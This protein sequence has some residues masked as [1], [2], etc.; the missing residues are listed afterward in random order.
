VS[1]IRVFACFDIEHDKDLG[2]R[3]SADSRRGGSSFQLS[4]RSEGGDV[5]DRW[6]AQTRARIRD[7]DHVIVI[8]GEHTAA[9]T[10]VNEELRIAQEEQKPYF[11]LWGRRERMCTMPPLAKRTESM[12]SWTHEV[13][14]Q[15]LSAALQNTQ[16][17]V[18][19]VRKPS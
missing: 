1:D 18:M 17:R 10:K 11:L 12:Y 15:Q 9:C 7:A 6:C 8:C 14:L 19:P 2:D 13:L 3:L 4:A 16:P 5:T